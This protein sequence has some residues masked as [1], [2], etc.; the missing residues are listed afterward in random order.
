MNRHAKFAADLCASLS[1]R[2][3]NFDR[4]GRRLPVV[5]NMEVTKPHDRMIHA[6]RYSEEVKQ[7]AVARVANGESMRKV[8]M[9]VGCA[10]NVLK[11]WTLNGKVPVVKAC[12][13]CAD[14]ITALRLVLASADGSHALRASVN[15]IAEQAIARA[16]QTGGGQ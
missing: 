5:H 15:Q 2:S 16:T 9:D 12:P 8:A 11:L 1:A 13:H 6:Q 3:V 7:T 4:A 10:T 14:L